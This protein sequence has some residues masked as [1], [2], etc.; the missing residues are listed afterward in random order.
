MVEVCFA[1]RLALLLPRH[2]RD[3]FSQ[4]EEGDASARDSVAV[5]RISRSGREK[6]FEFAPQEGKLAEHHRVLQ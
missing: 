4:R 5:R 3:G 6:G 2:K 1:V